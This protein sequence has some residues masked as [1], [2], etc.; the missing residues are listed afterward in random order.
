MTQQIK[1]EKMKKNISKEQALKRLEEMEQEL[2]EANNSTEYWSHEY[3]TLL[4]THNNLKYTDSPVLKFLN[5]CSIIDH[6][7]VEDFIKSLQP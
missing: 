7:K 5:S 6:S 1:T 2:H 4:T 3:H